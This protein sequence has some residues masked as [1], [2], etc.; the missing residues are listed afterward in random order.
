VG[1]LVSKPTCWNTCVVIQHVGF[2]FGLDK[3]SHHGS[4]VW[5]ELSTHAIGG[6]SDNDFI[7]AAKIDK[8][9]IKRKTAK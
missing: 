7:L 2:F 9:P 6:L 4:N 1:A 5:I 8:L 3:G